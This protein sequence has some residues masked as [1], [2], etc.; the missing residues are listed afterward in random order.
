VAL[1][2]RIATAARFAFLA[3]VLAVAVYLLT[4]ISGTS[5]PAGSRAPPRVQEILRA[6]TA[7]LTPRRLGAGA[8]LGAAGWVLQL[9]TYHLAAAAVGLRPGFAGNVTLLFAVN[10]GFVVPVTPGAV[11][12]FQ[13]VCVATAACPPTSPS[14][15]RSYFRRS[16]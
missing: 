2:S 12:V 9:V 16:K 15:P 10:L 6:R 14:P 13:A 11:G 7:R 4:P 5:G 3:V 1:P 8:M